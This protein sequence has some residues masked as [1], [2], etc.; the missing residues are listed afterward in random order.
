MNFSNSEYKKEHFWPC[1]KEFQ[2]GDFEKQKFL[3]QHKYYK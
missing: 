1:S 3:F 2:D